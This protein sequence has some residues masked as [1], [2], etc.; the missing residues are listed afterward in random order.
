MVGYAPS[1]LTHPTLA[2]EPFWLRPRLKGR[3]PGGHRLSR[4]L[5]TLGQ[6]GHCFGGIEA[7]VD[8]QVPLDFFRRRWWKSWG[9]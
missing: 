2:D 8:D 6:F 7:K 5:I 9:M 4:L 3:A 1:A